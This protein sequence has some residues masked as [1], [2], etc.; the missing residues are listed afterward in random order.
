MADPHVNPATGVWD[1]N[2]Y[3]Q[4]YGN[5]GG[6]GG[7]GGSPDYAS[8]AREQL[9]LQQEANAPAIASLQ[10]SIPEI[11]NKYSQLT[12]QLKSQ[13]EPLEKRYQNLLSQITANQQRD[14][15]RTSIAGSRE[16]GRRGISSQSGFYDQYQN[17]QLSPITQFYT[18]QL[19][20]TG[21]NRE[22]AIKA[23]LD[24]IANVPIQETAEERAVK[25]A[26]AQLQAGGA[27]S[28]IQNS[29]GIYQNQLQAAQQ[30]A[31][32]ARLQQ[33]QNAELAYKSQTSP[34]ELQLLQAQV[35]KATSPSAGTGY[36][37]PSQQFNSPQQYL[38]DVQEYV[39]RYGVDAGVSAGLLGPRGY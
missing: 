36:L 9:K 21:Q 24:Q 11:Q 32:E 4:N 33:A 25:N 20:T 35:K 28:A 37:T 13:Q 39:K 14:E 30:A 2:W 27:S 26:I 7:G 38:N 22:D 34:L 12:S 5:K 17:Q 18:G 1:D 23:L 19:A 6:G 29:L 16:L 8:I 15:Q 10:S 3:A 31:Q